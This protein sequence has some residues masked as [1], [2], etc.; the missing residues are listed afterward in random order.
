MHHRRMDTTRKEKR[1]CLIKSLLAEQPRYGHIGI[2]ADE[3]GRK[4]LLRSICIDGDI[5]ETIER[6]KE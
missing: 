4:D 6:I 3:K 1:I 2:P 5:G